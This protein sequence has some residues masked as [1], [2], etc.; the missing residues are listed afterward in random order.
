[1]KDKLDQDQISA[2]ISLL[3]EKSNFIFFKQ[4][5][6]TG[7]M[8]Y[9][10]RFYAFR[11]APP[12]SGEGD[13]VVENITWLVAKLNGKRLT[14]EGTVSINGGYD[15]LMYWI[16]KHTKL[17]QDRSTTQDTT[18]RVFSAREL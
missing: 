15:D 13:T 8:N 3:R 1:M 14:G 9:I 12:I 16:N 18:P 6:V 17:Y 5:R 7:R 10:R 11:V 4:V 2:C